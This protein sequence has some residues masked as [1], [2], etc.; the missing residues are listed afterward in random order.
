MALPTTTAL[1]PALAVTA[2]DPNELGAMGVALALIYVMLEL[3]KYGVNR[4]TGTK[5]YGSK[6]RERD[7]KLMDMHDSKRPDDGT[8]RWHFPA[9]CT[10]VLKEISGNQKKIAQM[11]HDDAAI[12]HQQLKLLEAI[13][14]R[15][16]QRCN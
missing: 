15:S 6:D 1:L 12:Q 5:G 2:N 9:E 16:E 7:N 13:N 14:N 4:F 11:L 3:I 10:T 8:Y